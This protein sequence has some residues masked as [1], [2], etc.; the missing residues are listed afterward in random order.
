[1][2]VLP[3]KAGSVRALP[4][5]STVGNAARPMRSEL[6]SKLISR[7]M[8]GLSLAIAAILSRSPIESE[9]VVLF[10][11]VLRN[12]TSSAFLAFS[13]GVVADDRLRVSGD[14]H[15]NADPEAAADGCSPAPANPTPN[16]RA[17][18]PAIIEQATL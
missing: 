7:S 1:M 3:F 17:R 6:N 9:R 8:L 5:A 16:A 14:H 4:S 2:K 18:P 11:R 10:F 12:F 13:A 15:Q